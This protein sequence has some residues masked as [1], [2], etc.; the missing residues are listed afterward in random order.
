MSKRARIVAFGSAGVLVLA[1]I[2]GAI[3]VGGFVGALLAFVLIA[4]GLVLATSLVFLEVGLSEDR[5]R[6]RDR[7]RGFTGGIRV[8]PSMRRVPLARR[9]TGR[10]RR[11]RD[12]RRRLE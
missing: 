5:D 10:L 6:A 1:G 9:T 2:V 4:S 7:S 12:H 8:E 11:E 3:V